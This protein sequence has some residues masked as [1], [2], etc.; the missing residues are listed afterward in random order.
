L[1]FYH[2]IFSFVPGLIAS[3]QGDSISFMTLAR[4]LRLISRYG[5]SLS[6]STTTG[7]FARRSETTASSS[8]AT[9]SATSAGLFE[10]QRIGD[11]TSGRDWNR[12]RNRGVN[13]LGFRAPQHGAFFAV[14]ADCV[15]LTEAEA[16]PWVHNGQW[17]DL[18]ARSGT[19]LFISFK[20]GALT[21]E[22]QKTV[23]EVLDIA[24]RP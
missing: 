6:S 14:D 21:A 2:L 9:P 10:L 11:D 19:P 18:L 4:F 5:G 12:V 15:A 16:I 1:T 20:R 24:S 22:Q 7:A 3:F 23:A 13:T 8:A 17:L